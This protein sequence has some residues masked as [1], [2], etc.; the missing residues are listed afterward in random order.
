[1][2]LFE[3]G[4]RE[5]NRVVIDR[6]LGSDALG[7]R[8]L[9]ARGQ[10]RGDELAVG[11][12]PT[13]HEGVVEEPLGFGRIAGQHHQPSEAVGGKAVAEILFA[14]PLDRLN[15]LSLDRLVELLFALGREETRLLRRRGGRLGGRCLERLPPPLE[16]FW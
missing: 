8:K 4:K 7:D 15:V 14:D 13:G 5:A 11:R 12:V 3:F 10:V 9:Q 16:V 6:E 1:M 2:V